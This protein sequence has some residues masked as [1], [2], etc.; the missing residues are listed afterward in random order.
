ME[1]KPKS[2]FGWGSKNCYTKIRQQL[3]LMTQGHCAFCD[4]FLGRE[5]RETVEHFRPK[6]RF[7]ELAYDWGNL[8]PCCDR[9][10]SEKK[11]QFD[12]RLLKPDD[13]DYDF[14]RY[15]LINFTT[16]K[17]EPRP[18]ATATDQARARTS[19]QLYGL[20]LPERLIARL[21]EDEHFRR[22]PSPNLD[23]YAYRFFLE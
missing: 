12:D 18:D 21:R 5:S 7:P 14:S 10:Q 13:M 17:L 22:D 20:N 23:D 3:A 9:C 19:I 16:G 8:F 15:F 6:R 1:S 4:G 11:E 2:R